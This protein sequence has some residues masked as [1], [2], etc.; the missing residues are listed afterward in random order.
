MKDSAEQL[1]RRPVGQRGYSHKPE[2]QGSES[3][4]GMTSAE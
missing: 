1:C 2:G 3:D 4:K